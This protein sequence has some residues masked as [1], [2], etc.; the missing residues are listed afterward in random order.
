M[1][2]ASIDNKRIA[3][4]TL[5]LYI[6]MF[7]IMGVSLVTFRLLLQTLGETDY[8]IYNVVG[9]VVVLFAFLNNAM[10]QSSQRFFAYYI[11][12]NDKLM[13]SR[14]FS[15]SVAIHL[16]IA[17]IAFVLAETV[18]LWFLNSYMNFPPDSMPAVNIVYQSCIAVF[19][20]QILI[21]PYHASI[22]SYERMSFYAYLSIIEVVLKLSA[23]LILFLFNTR[24]LVIYSYA[25]VGVT[26]IIALFYRFYCRRRFDVCR[27]AVSFDKEIIMQ[28][29][30]FSGWNM[31]GGIGNIGASQGVN[32]IFNIFHGVA[33]N[34]AM[35]VANQ[36][37]GA[38]SS[39]VSNF[40]TA[41]NPQIVKSYA[42][43][44]I[45]DF[46]SLIF[47]ASRVSFGLIFVIG[48]PV[49][50]LAK[51]I[52]SVWLTEVPQY[53]VE[54]TQLIVIFCMIDAISG[55]LWTAAQ[56]SGRIKSYMIII[57]LMIFSN[58]PAAFVILYLG[59]SPV[60]VFVYKVAMNL[61][62]HFVRIGY[63]LYSIDFPGWRYLMRVMIPILCTVAAVLPIPLFLMWRGVAEDI[64]GA[65][66]VASVAVVEGIVTF[67]FILLTRHERDIVFKK[68]SRYLR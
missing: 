67:L 64:P 35:G 25:I 32:I 3:R 20:I 44:E 8:G 52:L 19:I 40:Q 53:A 6:R 61:L 27:T 45:R 23:V 30:G 39:F 58:V 26:L 2:N 50:L 36:V 41:F 56:A 51:S 48:L 47:R 33:L 54:F 13:L 12:N 60:W 46:Q 29:A 68:F 34:A 10:S 55:P 17:A 49:I 65:I 16:I 28:L 66:A 7:M 9:G 18:G 4:N 62:I 42:N 15:A 24:R 14:M 37:S 5:M 63:L 21:I 43:N 22:I 1:Q 31:L 59:Y 38:V 57:S 11:G